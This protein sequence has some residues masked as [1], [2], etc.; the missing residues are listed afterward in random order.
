MYYFLKGKGLIHLYLQNVGLCSITGE[1]QLKLELDENI[2]VKPC[3]S[4]LA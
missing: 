3:P 1:R 4:K 2:F